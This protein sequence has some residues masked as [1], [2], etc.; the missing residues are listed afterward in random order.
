M[1]I[2]LPP[3]FATVLNEVQ[4]AWEATNDHFKTETFQ[5][6][7]VVFQ[8][9]AVITRSQAQNKLILKKIEKLPIKS[10]TR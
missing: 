4:R 9:A 3:A 10:R 8:G 2:S 6:V 5:Q 7:T 1:K